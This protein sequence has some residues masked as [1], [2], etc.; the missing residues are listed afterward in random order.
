MA[1]QDVLTAR[2][3]NDHP[4]PCN[5]AGDCVSEEDAA[6]VFAPSNLEVE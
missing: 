2:T 4:L 3:C 1:Y 6:E 5:T